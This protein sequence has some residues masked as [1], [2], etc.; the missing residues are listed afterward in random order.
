MIYT[1]ERDH[2]HLPDKSTLIIRVYTLY[3]IRCKLAV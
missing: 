2:Y 3:V 1:R